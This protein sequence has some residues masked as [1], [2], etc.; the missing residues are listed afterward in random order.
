[1]IAIEKDERRC[2]RLATWMEM[3]IEY[4]NFSRQSL[5]IVRH[6]DFTTDSVPEFERSI[7]NRRLLIYLN[8]YNGALS[9]LGGPQDGLEKKLRNCKVGSIVIALDN[10][11][12]RDLNWDEE[13]YEIDVPNDH[14]SWTS[15][16]TGSRKHLIIFKYLK[17][18]DDAGKVDLPRPRCGNVK[19]LRYR[20][21]KKSI[22][23]V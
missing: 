13:R 8:N 21:L 17:V 18:T 22:N 10:F 9:G 11:F 1:M 14:M 4:H 2:E 6:G 20:F 23:F 7:R 15:N 3:L 5:P 16:P 12:H 19:K